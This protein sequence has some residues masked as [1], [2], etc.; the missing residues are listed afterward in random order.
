M[1][2]LGLVKQVV[3]ISSPFAKLCGIVAGISG[4][5]TVYQR[6]VNAAGFFEPGAEIRAKAPQVDVF[7]DA[8]LKVLAVFENE[9]AGEDDKAL[10]HGALEVLVPMVEQLGELAG[11]GTC[12]LVFQL[13]GRVECDTSLRCV[14]NHKTDF[15][16]LGQLQIGVEIH[17][18]IQAAG[19]NVDE[20]QT[21][22]GFAIQ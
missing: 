13:A 7:A 4:N 12:G 10:V 8:L 22:H 9:L 11:I 19:N 2:N 14:G 17:I 21:V 16:L 6:A 3:V 15:R 5:D 18:G 1:E 20:V